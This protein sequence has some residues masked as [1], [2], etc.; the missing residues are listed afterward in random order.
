[1]K[2]RNFTANLNRDRPDV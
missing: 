2:Y 1:M